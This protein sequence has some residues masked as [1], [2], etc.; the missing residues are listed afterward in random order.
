MTDRK[1]HG[2]TLIEL[3]VASGIFAVVAAASLAM[4]ANSETI[5]SKTTLMRRVSEV[6]RFSLE[7]IARELRLA[8]GLIVQAEQGEFNQTQ[9]PFVILDAGGQPALADPVTNWIIGERLRIATT[10]LS[11][12]EQK[13]YLILLDE[14]IL[15]HRSLVLRTCSDLLCSTASDSA[16]SSDSVEIEEVTF[17]SLASQGGEFD[18]QPFVSVRLKA[19]SAGSRLAESGSQTV[20]T[21]ITTRDYQF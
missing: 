8:N 20:E 11:T 10:D 13:I 18:R 2:F 3:L 21:V 1:S 5:R 16:L 19:T 17:K 7:A 15:G 9:P 6:T 14:S 12:G 4:V